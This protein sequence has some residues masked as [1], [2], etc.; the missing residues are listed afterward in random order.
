MFYLVK[1]VGADFLRALCLAHSCSVHSLSGLL[2]GLR[3]GLPHRRHGCLVLDPQLCSPMEVVPGP[4]GSLSYI[5]RNGFS[6]LSLQTAEIGLTENSGESGLCFEI[7]FRR[8]KSRDTYILQ[9]SSPEAKQAWTSDITRILWEQATRNKGQFP[10]SL[11]IWV[12][13]WSGA[14]ER[15]PRE[16]M[17][18]PLVR[19]LA[20]AC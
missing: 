16:R 4:T 13:I 2:R 18:V 3:Q 9:A 10:P 17:G 7:W 5:M 8:W 6:S 15:S 11:S 1:W 14:H 20:R 19:S 12:P